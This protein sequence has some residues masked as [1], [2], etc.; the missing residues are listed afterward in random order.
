MA[1]VASG[2]EEFLPI[3]ENAKNYLLTLQADESK[4]YRQEDKFYGGIGYGGSQR[5]DLSNTQFAFEALN[6]AGLPKDHESY[7][8]SLIFLSR[9]QNYS[10]TNTYTV[11]VDGISYVSGNDGGGAYYPGNS[12]AG[13]LDLPNGQKVPRSYGS[14]SYALLRGYL[15]A[16]LPQED[17]RLK[18]VV[19]WIQKNYTVH[20]NPGFDRREDLTAG[21]QGYFYYLLTMAK[22]LDALGIET[23]KT[24]DGVEHNWRQELRDKLLSLQKPD[25]SWV[26]E[27]S[28]RWWE[29]DPV[30]ATSYGLTILGYL[31]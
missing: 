22:A 5:T 28:E 2:K 14:M 26:N 15:F 31:D 12:M 25:G 24:P 19:S 3:I 23:V 16:G 11:E 1:F 4:G 10:E 6:A 29:G 20:E 7:K 8:K 18:A 27:F 30:L 17:P 13:Y 9:S 21:M